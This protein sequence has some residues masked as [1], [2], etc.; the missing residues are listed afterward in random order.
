MW[1]KKRQTRKES[2][3]ANKAVEG[4]RQ[5]LEKIK[6][7]ERKVENVAVDMHLIRKRN[8]FSES[9]AAIMLRQEGGHK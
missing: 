6:R 7:R 8:H 1:L 9:L 4:S 3:E 5:E 2:P